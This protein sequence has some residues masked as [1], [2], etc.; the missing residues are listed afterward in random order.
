MFKIYIG[1]YMKKSQQ[2]CLDTDTETFSPT[3]KGFSEKIINTY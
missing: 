2:K 3:G 1:I